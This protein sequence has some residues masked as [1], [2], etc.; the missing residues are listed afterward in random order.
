MSRYLV[1]ANQTLG[2]EPLREELRARIADDPD[3]GFH[4]VVPATPLDHYQ[5]PVDGERI[6]VAEHRLREALEELSGLPAKV[7]GEVG[8]ADPVT[9][10]VEQLGEDDY[11]A[12]IVSTLPE[13]ISRWLGMDV[14]SRLERRID[15]PI[16]HVIG[17][18][19]PEL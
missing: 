2:G 18:E 14:T 9:A 16:T 15:V 19:E 3:C 1:L 11:A 4:V 13:G 7:S 10:V 8:D 17:H 6:T 12:V 5:F